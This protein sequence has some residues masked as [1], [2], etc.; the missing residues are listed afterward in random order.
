MFKNLTIML[1]YSSL[2]VEEAGY[3]LKLIPFINRIVSDWLCL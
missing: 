1:L 2:Y 3:S